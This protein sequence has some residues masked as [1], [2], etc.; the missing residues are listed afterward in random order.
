MLAFLGIIVQEFVHLPDAQ[1]S[2]PVAT[3]ALLQI[4][5]AGLWQIFL[6]CGLCEFILHKGKLSSVDMFDNGAIPGELGF[7]PMGMKITEKVKLQE[8]KNGRL[9]MLGVGG[10]IHSMLFYKVPI[11]AQLLNFQPMSI[12]L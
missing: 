5:A 7:N 8:I 4:P 3:E 11:I 6:F 1:F 9:A 10:V 12:P 2:N